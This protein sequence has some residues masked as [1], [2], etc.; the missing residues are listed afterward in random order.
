MSDL[1]L[2]GEVQKYRAELAAA[3]TREQNRQLREQ[4]AKEAAEAQKKYIVEKT[5]AAIREMAGKTPEFLLE[6]GFTPIIQTKK[7]YIR[8][9][10]IFKSR[11][12]VEEYEE[13]L[14]RVRIVDYCVREAIPG[15]RGNRW[16]DY[17]PTEYRLE[18]KYSL[19]VDL[20]EGSISTDDAE[21]FSFATD[22]EIAPHSCLNVAKGFGQQD[23]LHAIKKQ[24]V[25]LNAGLLYDRQVPRALQYPLN[26]SHV[27]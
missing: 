6:N 27:N 15:T 16:M 22:D 7:R 9:N 18:P 14:R 13:E 19:W 23:L 5:A 11:V 3:D 17:D 1:D 25:K 10:G 26:G 2:S 4:Q 21:P 12:E 20:R 24:L 8:H